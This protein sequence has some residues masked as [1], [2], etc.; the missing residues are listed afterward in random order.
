VLIP[1]L[2][3]A[4]GGLYSKNDY[5][6]PPGDSREDDNYQAKIDLYYQIQEWLGAGIGYKYMRKNSNVG[7]FDFTDNQFMVS[8]GVAY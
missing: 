6:E 8:V 4:V 7:E 5:N 2:T 3:L 1:K